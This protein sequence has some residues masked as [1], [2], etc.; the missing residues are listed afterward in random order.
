MWFFFCLFSTRLHALIYLL[1]CP[2]TLLGLKTVKWICSRFLL[3]ETT[4]SGMHLCVV[5][6][7][8]VRAFFEEETNSAEQKNRR[9]RKPI[10]TLN[11]N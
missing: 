8:R 9:R 10:K 3:S 7:N 5:V 6:I 11:E 2:D 1:S 4:F